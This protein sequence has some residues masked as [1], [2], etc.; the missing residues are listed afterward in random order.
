MRCQMTILLLAGAIQCLA[1]SHR[2]A[3]I[4]FSDGHE[5]FV[6]DAGFSYTEPGAFRP[7]AAARVNPGDAPFSTLSKLRKYPL[8]I[9]VDGYWRALP[10]GSW[11]SISS[12]VGRAKQMRCP[13]AKGD[14]FICAKLRM[15]DGS[16]I[17]GA[18]H[19]SPLFWPG[20]EYVIR[21]VQT[22]GGG[23]SSVTIPL[24]DLAGLDCGPDGRCS[25]I[26]RAGRCSE[27]GCLEQGVELRGVILTLQSTRQF[28]FADPRVK[29]DA[30]DIH[31]AGAINSSVPTTVMYSDIEAIR[32]SLNKE[33]AGSR[34][35]QVQLAGGKVLT[36]LADLPKSLFGVTE[37]GAIV[38][39]DL[40]ELCSR[41]MGDTI[42]KS[43]IS[44][45]RFLQRREEAKSR[46]AAPAASN[47]PAY[48]AQIPARVAQCCGLRSVKWDAPE[49]S[50]EL[51]IVSATKLKEQP[52]GP[53]VVVTSM[54]NTG[55]SPL[56]VSPTRFDRQSSV[57]A[58]DTGLPIMLKTYMQ[59]DESLQTIDGPIDLMPGKSLYVLHRVHGADPEARALAFTSWEFDFFS[60][61]LSTAPPHRFNRRG[62]PVRKRQP[63]LVLPIQE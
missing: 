61:D 4:T 5:L 3:R 38:H 10:Q 32:F 55:V 39:F 40:W 45:I 53:L 30:I 26:V 37:D 23:E 57:G 8:V 20:G 28:Q 27:L 1:Q 42:R 13:E 22:T 6:L 41:G 31:L 63:P 7:A 18:I 36:G 35:Q 43:L 33:G 15:N 2:M 54:K 48:L 44:E 11:N 56:L 25:G 46:P 17:I 51:A 47:P 21:A 9:N 16:T 14:K 50:V 60:I 59:V 12:Y 24:E 34:T 49:A 52:G 19:R 58:D 29:A 62:W